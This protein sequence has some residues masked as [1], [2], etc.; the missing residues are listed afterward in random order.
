MHRIFCDLQ[1]GTG[2]QVP[3]DERT[4]IDI[5][6]NLLENCALSPNRQLYGNLHN[7]G[8]NLIS[9][10]HDPDSRHLEDYGVMADVATAMRDPTFYRWHAFIDSICAKYKGTLPAYTQ[11]Q[12]TY[13][14]VTVNSVNVQITA[15]KAAPNTLLTYWQ[16][17]DVDLA[18]GLDFGPGNVYAQVKQSLVYPSITMI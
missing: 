16:R 18:A 15:R 3:L 7:M 9:Y 10:V 2:R 14:G 12:L 11:R 1:Q 5:L 13:E 6:G 17:S 8:H 4:G